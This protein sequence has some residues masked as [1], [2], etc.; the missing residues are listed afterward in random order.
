MKAFDFVFADGQ[1]EDDQLRG[2]VQ[3]DRADFLPPCGRGR[4]S[5]DACQVGGGCICGQAVRTAYARPNKEKAQRAGFLRGRVLYQF[6]QT[7]CMD[8][9]R[10][11]K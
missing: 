1:K 5:H 8:W 2:R 6:F 9:G 7:A 4:L 10:L 11:K 3:D